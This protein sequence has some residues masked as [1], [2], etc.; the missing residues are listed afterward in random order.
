MPSVP[1]ALSRA[2]ASGAAAS[3]TPSGA[4]RACPGRVGEE[5]PHG[6]VRAGL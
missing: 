2:A 4:T 1:L 3:G 5:A 6:V